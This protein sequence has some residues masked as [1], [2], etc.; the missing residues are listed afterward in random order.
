M[1]SRT[2]YFLIGS[3]LVVVVGMAA[4]LVAYYSG[5]RS[6]GGGARAD[7]AY[8]PAEARAVGYADV[9]TIMDSQFRQRLRETMPVSDGREHL[10]AATGIDIEKDIDSVVAG[11]LGTA[12]QGGA[13]IIVRGRFDQTRIERLATE[14][15]ATA[16]EYKTVRVLSGP[17]G[18]QGLTGV[19]FLQ[20]TVVA[21]GHLNGLK[22]AIDAEAGRTSVVSDTALMRAVSDI[23]SGGDAWLVSRTSAFPAQNELPDMV[24]RHL[25]GL[26]WVALSASVNETVRAQVRVEA[27]DE[28]AAE[29]LR[30]VI[31]G[32]IASVRMFGGENAG[33]AEALKSIET[34]GRGRTVT[35]SFSAPASMVDLLRF[36]APG[37]A[38][39]PSPAP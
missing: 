9:R 23:E 34:A 4:G 20:P 21:F 6:L 17:A 3:A 18:A 39:T 19:A 27:R 5:V 30:A 7:M 13:V 22:A 38:P 33:I 24:R 11:I 31:G 16:E 35:L 28:K 8:V 2:R 15:G 32:A 12:E 29:D 37:A 36:R 25:D 26:E 14:H 10:L 1:G